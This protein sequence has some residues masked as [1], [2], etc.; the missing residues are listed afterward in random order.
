ML[1]ADK[2]IMLRKKN[3]W[4]QEELAEKLDVTRQSVSKWEG[5]QSAPDIQKIIAMSRIFGVST[6]FLLKDEIES[7][8]VPPPSIGAGN[9]LGDVSEEKMPL[10]QVSKIEAQDFLSLRKWAASRIAS[11]TLL[12]ILS[13]VCM[14]MLI[15]AAETGI[16]GISEN[17]AVGI[18]LGT[19]ILIVAVACVFFVDCGIKSSPYEFLEK[20][21]FEREEGVADIIGEAKARFAF[22]YSRFNMFGVFTAILAV[23]PLIVTTL[24]TEDEFIIM[25][26]LCATLIIAGIAVWLFIYAGVIHASMQKLICEGE[27]KDSAKSRKRSE[28]LSAAYWL[29]V[30]AVFFIVSNMTNEWRFAGVIWP[31][32]G[33]VYGALCALYSAFRKDK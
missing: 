27:Y 2:I 20:E 18:G 15:A 12:C 9:A 14:F 3:G 33:V 28:A 31:A 13:P 25:L 22:A 1:L 32:A 19:L 5:A 24:F 23:V 6:D 30:T 7:E 26:S 8:D 29:T 4:S 10:R 17:A 21:D 11:A 16:W